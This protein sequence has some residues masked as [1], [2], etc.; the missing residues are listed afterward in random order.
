MAL[1]YMTPVM[2]GSDMVPDWAMPIFNMNPLTPVIEIYRD[3]LYYKQV[4]QLSSLMLA[5]GVGLVA[6]ILGEFLFAKLQKGF[7]ENF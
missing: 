7:A 1:Q 4:P 2:Y 3:I 6:V 5:L